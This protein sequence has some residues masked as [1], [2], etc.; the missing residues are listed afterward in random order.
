MGLLNYFRGHMVEEAAASKPALFTIVRAALLSPRCMQVAVSM[1]KPPGTCFAGG[2]ANGLELRRSL[3]LER[4]AAA[5][6]ENWA[7]AA[8]CTKKK[9]GNIA[10][11]RVFRL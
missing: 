9:H 11:T 5:A 4:A 6:G 10:K 2:G 8:P 7:T 1:E 3:W